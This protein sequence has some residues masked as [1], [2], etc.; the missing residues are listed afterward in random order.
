MSNKPNTLPEKYADSATLSAWLLCYPF[1]AKN[2]KAWGIH[3]QPISARCKEL[4]PDIVAALYPESRPKVVQLSQPLPA[5][6]VEAA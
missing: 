3:R 6:S 2:V 5:V 1:M 4:F